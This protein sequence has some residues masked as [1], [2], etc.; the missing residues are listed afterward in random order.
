MGDKYLDIFELLLDQCSNRSLKNKDG[1]G[2]LHVA[3]REKQLA[4]CDKLIAHGF[5]H[6]MCD[7]K[8]WSPLDIAQVN[9]DGDV[10]NKFGEKLLKNIDDLVPYRA[11]FDKYR[12]PFVSITVSTKKQQSWF[13][14]HSATQSPKPWT[15]NVAI[16]AYL[17]QKVLLPDDVMSDIYNMACLIQ[18]NFSDLPEMDLF[19]K[20]GILQLWVKQTNKHYSSRISPRKFKVLYHENVDCKNY[21]VV[22]YPQLFSFGTDDFD[23]LT[24]Q[25][26]IRFD[27]TNLS[28]LPPYGTAA[29][30]ALEN[31]QKQ[32]IRD[33]KDSEVTSNLSS[34]VGGYATCLNATQRKNQV[35]LL[36]IGA[37][38]LGSG[39]GCV[40]HLFIN[41]KDLEAR[42]FSKTQFQIDIG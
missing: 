27:E 9:K 37:E 41:R 26:V 22:D 33:L 39:D 13:A 2:P 16:C 11:L 35:L 32:Y 30:E 21:N 25:Y 15:S 19:P 17:P 42:D 40:G 23:I 18:I 14:R 10:C 6:N 20:T 4:I 31:E 34:Y 28:M 29:E 36:Q 7:K 8:G 1:W 3:V 5:D 38:V 12:M 24:G